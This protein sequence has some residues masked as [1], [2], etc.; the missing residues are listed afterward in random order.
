LRAFEQDVAPS[1]LAELTHQIV[2]R[3]FSGACVYRDRFDAG[4]FIFSSRAR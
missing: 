3:E 1:A 2:K 4:A